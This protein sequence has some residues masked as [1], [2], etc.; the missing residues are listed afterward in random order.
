MSIP[1]TQESKMDS[2]KYE[3]SDRQIEQIIGIVE[4]AVSAAIR[5]AVLN[6]VGHESK[7]QRGRPKRPNRD[8]RLAEKI[9]AALEKAQGM[10]EQ[11]P[12]F[13]KFLALKAMPKTMLR[14]QVGNSHTNFDAVLEQMVADDRLIHRKLV[15][16]K[17]RFLSLFG[18]P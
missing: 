3:L 2:I 6:V 18:L 11:N 12:E 7:K 15:G 13:Q 17:G 10:A 4:N 16:S 8:E 1:Q 9:I 5:E 14:R